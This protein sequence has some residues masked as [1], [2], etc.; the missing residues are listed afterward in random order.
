[1]AGKQHELIFSFSR[2]FTPKP[3]KGGFKTFVYNIFIPITSNF[4]C[5][6]TPKSPKG[7]FKNLLFLF[8]SSISTPKYLR[9]LLNPFVF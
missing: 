9:G 2:F 3:P 8:L 7:G 4:L 6:L 1:M 5:F